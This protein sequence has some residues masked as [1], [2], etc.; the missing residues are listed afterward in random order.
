MD[1]IVRYW[2]KVTQRVKVRYC[3]TSSLGHSTHIDL[4]KLFNKSTELLDPSK[5]IQVLMDWPNV[6][7]KF[8]KELSSSRAEIEIPALINI[9]TCPLHTDY[10]SF[11]SGANEADWN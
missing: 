11:Q 6:N 1:L 3:E 7:L 10:S 9:G 5:M 4:L 8:S 2:D